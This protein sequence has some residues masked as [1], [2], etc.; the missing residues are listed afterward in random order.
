[1]K[2]DQEAKD[3]KKES[4]T[5]TQMKIS[6]TEAMFLLSISH[7]EKQKEMNAMGDQ[8]VFGIN[9]G[10]GPGGSIKDD[11]IKQTRDYLDK[12]TRLK[13][14]GIQVSKKMRSITIQH[15]IKK[16][17]MIHIQDLGISDYEEATG[18]FPELANY[19]K[20]HVNELLE[21]ISANTQ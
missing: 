1:M 17:L 14:D 9:S 2:N 5:Q 6:M 8:N 7:K 21:C 12:F 18:L 3:H 10:F 4:K 16:E 13:N 11:V 15:K 19:P 20:E